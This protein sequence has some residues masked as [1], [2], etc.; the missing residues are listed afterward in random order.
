MADFPRFVTEHP[1]PEEDEEWAPPDCHRGF[2]FLCAECRDWRSA[3]ERKIESAVF[4][5]RI[6]PAAQGLSLYAAV[7]V[8]RAEA[9]GWPISLQARSHVAELLPPHPTGQTSSAK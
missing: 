6:D 5:A 8:F 1:N 3:V 7:F 4:R 2:Q 9:A